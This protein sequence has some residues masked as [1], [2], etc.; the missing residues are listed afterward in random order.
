VEYLLLYSAVGLFAGFTAGLLGVGGGL[1]IVPALVLLFRHQGLDPAVLVHVAIGTSL[2]VIIVTS[3]SSMWAHH[4]HGAVRWE[5]VRRMA[6][7][8]VI[9]GLLGAAIA[10]F[11][12]AT[13]L[14]TFFGLFELLVAA[15][16][17]FH[18]RASARRA[19]PSAAGLTLVSGGIGLVS[20][21]VGIGG[22]TLT[23]PFLTWCRIKIHEAVAT[24]AAAGLPIAVAGAAGFIVFGWL[25]E[26]LPDGATGY[27]YW[28]AFATIAVASVAMA[29]VGAWAAHRLPTEI[30]RRV[31]ALLLVVLGVRML[32]FG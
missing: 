11:V 31:F 14:R 28:P 13:G 18:W 29:P 16:M 27:V 32:W 5:L 24:S 6:P 26:R 12:P 8:L 1:I 22:G 15:Q 20:A 23:V 19:L 21:I 9:G 10:R 2:A 7:G 4:R 30:L 17:A 3:V 25:N